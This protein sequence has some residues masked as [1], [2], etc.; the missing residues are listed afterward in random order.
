MESDGGERPTLFRPV[1]C[2]K[3][4]RTGYYG[5]FA[6]HEVMPVTEEIERLIAERAHS[7]DL[8]KAAIADGMLPLRQAGL[9]TVRNGTTSIEE[10]LRVIA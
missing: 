8:K 10:V 3:C 1:G 6:I 4:S 7:E 9:R 5:R 2:G